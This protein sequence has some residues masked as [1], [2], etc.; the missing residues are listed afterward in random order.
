MSL[1]GVDYFL[2]AGISDNILRESRS[3]SKNITNGTLPHERR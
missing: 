3:E 2:I 1:T